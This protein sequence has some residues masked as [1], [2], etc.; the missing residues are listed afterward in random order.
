MALNL[1]G[2]HLL[3]LALITL[4]TK[5]CQ[6]AVLETSVLIIGKVG[7]FCTRN[8]LCYRVLILDLDFL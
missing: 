3:N 2:K 8:N 1:T 5:S 4:L 7:N 6:L